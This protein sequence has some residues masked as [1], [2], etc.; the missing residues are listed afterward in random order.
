MLWHA[1][2][3]EMNTAR[4]IA[5]AGAAPMTVAAAGWEA[6]AAA[7]RSQAAELASRL[8]VLGEAWEGVS[9][10]RAIEAA[11]PMVGWLENA[12]EQAQ[13]RAARADAQATAY[14]EAMLSTPD[15][16][17]IAEN[18]VTHAVLTATNFLG[19]NTLPIATKEFDYFV[20]MWNQAAAAMDAYQAQTS[21]NT[22]FEQL[23]P[24]AP[25]LDPAVSQAVTAGI[26]QLPD[27]SSQIGA[28]PIGGVPLQQLA[29][30][31]VTMSGPMQALT[32]PL[33]QVTSLFGQLGGMGGVAGG[34]GDGDG[35]Q[36]GLLGA[37]PLSNHPLAGGSGPSVGSG[38]QR[39]EAEPGLGG[40]SPRTPLLADLLDTTDVQPPPSAAAADTSEA[41]GLAPIA[42]TAMGR[43]APSSGGSTKSTLVAPASTEDENEAV[44]PSWG[45][46]DDW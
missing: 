1:L 16:V 12:A 27:L 25:I 14:T 8:Q 44:G 24:V 17:E 20:R 30:G 10:D 11:A 18:H 40:T 19:I 26:S 13:S 15:L 3:P 9:S 37:T 46:D 35:A 39:A 2:P 33:W 41:N 23:P 43:S 4:L 6:L 28:L 34:M 38:L 22:L 31:A 32:Q 36:V 5:G 45:E 29:N 21:I 7:L 42:P